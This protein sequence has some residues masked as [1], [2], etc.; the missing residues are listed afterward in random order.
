MHRAARTVGML[1]SGIP[2]AIEE[3]AVSDLLVVPVL[4]GPTA[5]SLRQFHTPT[6]ELMVLA[7]TSPADLTNAL[8]PDQPWVLLSESALRD[9]V[10]GLAGRRII[11]IDPTRVHYAPV[12]SAA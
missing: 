9:M 2:A 5:L 4:K 8:G 11:A 1:R 6:S 12:T 3:G 7:F 10:D